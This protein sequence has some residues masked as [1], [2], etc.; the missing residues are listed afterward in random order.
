VIRV[1]KLVRGVNGLEKVTI[2]LICP[3]RVNGK[4]SR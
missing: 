3:R 4:S 1:K 2:V